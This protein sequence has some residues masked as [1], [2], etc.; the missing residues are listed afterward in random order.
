MTVFLL[1][2]LVLYVFGLTIWAISRAFIGDTSLYVL[3]LNFLGIW[4]F[5]PLLVY[6]PWVIYSRH[7]AA[8]LLVVIPFGLFIWFYGGMFFPKGEQAVKSQPAFTIL[9]FN[10]QGLNTNMTAFLKVLNSYPSDVLAL[11]EVSELSEEVLQDALSDNFP[12]KVYYRPN[13]LAVYSRFPIVDY[14]V[15]PAQ[16]WPFQS[17]IFSTESYPIHI[18]N[19]HLARTGIMLFFKTWNVNDIRELAINRSEQINQIYM[20]IHRIGLPA[21]VAC[22]CNMTDLTSSYAEM[23]AGLKDAYRERGCGFGHTFLIPRGF[24]INSKV[25]LP[26]QRI[27]YLFY[28][29]DISLIEIKVISEDM[30][31]D[32]RPNWAQFALD[33]STLDTIRG[34]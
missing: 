2:T 1:S 25:N 21:I 33:S 30:G 20:V 12:Y 14:K 31:S 34:D 9:S 15:Y 28:S 16:P 23:T 26:F 10:M 8:A 7:K 22:D 32:H 29:P 3:G 24:E 13:G 18:I 4:L 6:I 17:I 5:S 19:A 27:D 11:Q